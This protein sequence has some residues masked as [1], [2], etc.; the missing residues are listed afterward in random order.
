MDGIIWKIIDL[1]GPN[2]LGKCGLEEE[3]QFSSFFVASGSL[4]SSILL[5]VLW[6]L[7]IHCALIGGFSLF[8][9]VSNLLD[10]MRFSWNN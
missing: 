2:Y 5:E 6:K 4:G 9:P 3:N 10:R 7:K 1:G 8:G